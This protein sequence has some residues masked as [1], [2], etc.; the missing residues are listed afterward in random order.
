M[1]DSVI[2]QTEQMVLVVMLMIIIMVKWV[3]C[4]YWSSLC[5]RYKHTH[6]HTHTMMLLRCE[7]AHILRLQLNI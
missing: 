3:K 2:N 6:I 1:H 7:T 5:S 4:M